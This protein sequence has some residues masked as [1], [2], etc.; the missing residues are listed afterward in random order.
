M[1]RFENIELISDPIQIETTILSL[2]HLLEK[3]DL[4]E[5]IFMI[6]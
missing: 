3:Y 4:G 1:R 2:R 6:V 5:E